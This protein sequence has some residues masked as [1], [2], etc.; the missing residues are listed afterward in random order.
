M[1]EDKSTETES[2]L[3]KAKPGPKP[4]AKPKAKIDSIV[5]NDP[6]GIT[7]MVNDSLE[8]VGIEPK[9]I[10][11]QDLIKRIADLEETVENLTRCLEH[12]ATNSGQGNTVV[13][14]GFERYTPTKSDMSRWQG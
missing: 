13:A 4:K 2:S 6:S 10:P 9:L 7:S 1:T 3:P 5:I 11:A 14:Y 8:A 12:T